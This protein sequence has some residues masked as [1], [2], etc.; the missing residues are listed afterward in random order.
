[1]KELFRAFLAAFTGLVPAEVA[2]PGTAETVVEMPAGSFHK[3]GFNLFIF[4]GGAIMLAAG[5]KNRVC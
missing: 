2:D 3:A 1:M 4:S 5:R